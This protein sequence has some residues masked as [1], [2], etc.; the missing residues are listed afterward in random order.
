[1]TELDIIA[2]AAILKS[3]HGH[4]AR[5]SSF[6][7]GTVWDTIINSVVTG[8]SEFLVILWVYAKYLRDWT[9]DGSN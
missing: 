1:V 4:R 3:Y 6:D 5:S 7:R 8:E 9:I 2:I